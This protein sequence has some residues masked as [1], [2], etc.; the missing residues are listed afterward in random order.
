MTRSNIVPLAGLKPCATSVR[1]SCRI[2]EARPHHADNR[3][4]AD[5]IEGDTLADRGRIARDL[6]LPEPMADHDLRMP[7][8]IARI[9]A[10][11]G[12]D[13]LG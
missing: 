2:V 11:H 7:G 10:S 5:A 4:V 13:L 6:P 8:I 3:E 9:A 12:P 1:D